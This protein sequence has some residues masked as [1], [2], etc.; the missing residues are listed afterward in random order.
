MPNISGIDSKK[1]TKEQL[2]FELT[3]QNIKTNK[4]IKRDGLIKELE[5]VIA[6]EIR[7]QKGKK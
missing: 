4:T 2:L 5:L 6:S 7:E 3:K 1:L